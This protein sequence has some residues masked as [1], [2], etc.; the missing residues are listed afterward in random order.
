VTL[1]VQDDGGPHPLD[2]IKIPDDVRQKISERLT[3]GS[4]FIVADTAINSANLNKG[5]DFVV[6]A[7]A[8]S[9]FKIGD[10]DEAPKTKKKRSRSY[11]RSYG[12]DGYGSRGRSSGRTFFFQGRNGMPWW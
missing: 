2:R 1:D 11:S 5:N 10:V 4:T 7:K 8:T 3:P 9:S 6:L 12:L